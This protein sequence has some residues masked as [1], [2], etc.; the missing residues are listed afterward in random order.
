[1]KAHIFAGQGIQ[2]KGMGG[3]LFDYFPEIEERASSILGYSVK[4]LCLEDPERR[5]G[6]TVFA[7]PAV[8]TVNYLEYQRLLES[9]TPPDWVMGHSLGEYSALCAAGVFHF[10][11]GLRLI[12]ER[13]RIMGKCSDGGMSAVIGLSS[14]RLTATLEKHG[15]SDVHA[16]NFNS[17][18]QTVIAGPTQRLE[19]AGTVLLQSGASRCIPLDVSGPFHCEMMKQARD[20]F[21]PFVLSARFSAPSIPVISNL[22][23]RPH[24]FDA[25]KNHL[26]DHLT[27]PVRW[28]ESLEFLLANGVRQFLEIGGRGILMK[29]VEEAKTQHSSV[30]MKKDQ[31]ETQVRPKYHKFNHLSKAAFSTNQLG[32]DEFRSEYGVR[33]CYIAGA[34][35][36][37]ISS[38]EMVAA[39]AKKSIL[40]SLGTGGLSIEEIRQNLDEIRSKLTSQEPFMVNLLANPN[41]PSKEDELV[42]LLLEKEITIIEAAAFT[43]ITPSL[44]R[45]R[46]AGLSSSNDSIRIGN[47][48]IAKVSRPEIASAFL[49]PPAPEIVQ[50]LFDKGLITGKQAAMSARVPMSDDICVEADS[51]GHTDHGVSSVLIPAMTSLRDS[52]MNEFG[53][54]RKIRIG[55]GGGIGD[56]GAA[57]AAFVLGA[58]FICTGSI[59]Q[60]TSEAGTSDLVK[61][62]LQQMDIHHTT[63]APAGDM[64]ELG[65][66]IQVLKKGVLFPARANR[67]YGL[68]KHFSAIEEID[69]KTT[70]L[71]QES[72]FSKSFTDVYRETKDFFSQRDPSQI[73]LAERNSKHKMALIFRWYFAHSVTCALNGTESQQ[74]NFQVHSGP[75]LGAFNRLVR[76]TKME[77][78]KHRHVDEIG[79]F[80]MEQATR[81]LFDRFGHPINTNLP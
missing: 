74:A 27:K 5:L 31:H 79:E 52:K 30:D 57:A 71:I 70:S 17:N 11:E 26:V 40:S 9:D 49:S 37:G 33:F 53:Y 14:E 55:A 4:E 46:C 32:S 69:D 28:S 39:L 36:R 59:N 61:D 38:P 3:K 56:P 25:L 58:D 44:V 63:Y 45:Y 67:L 60:C 50:S 8:F 7:Q 15:F 73:E 24:T 64:F 54:P 19:E 72:Y 81:L 43:R 34:M 13:G 42:D 66:Q 35:F 41:N 18:S 2:K 1:M 12:K 80:I 76:G 51:G 47:R 75:A 16:A 20:E 48:V 10:E 6:N 29:F 77:S 65:A 62:M 21:Q 23:A 78:W 68:Y 22:T